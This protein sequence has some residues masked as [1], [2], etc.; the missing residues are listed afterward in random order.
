M[1]SEMFEHTNEPADWHAVVSAGL[2]AELIEQQP[3]AEIGNAQRARDVALMQLLAARLQGKLE[4]TT[5]V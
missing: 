2:E 1:Y 5:D 4:Y 3:L